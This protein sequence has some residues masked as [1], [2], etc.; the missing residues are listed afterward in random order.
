MTRFGENLPIWQYYKNHGQI[1]K[2]L[3]SV[4]QNFEPTLAHCIKETLVLLFL[5]R[6]AHW[7]E[8]ERVEAN[9]FGQMNY[10]LPVNSFPTKSQTYFFHCS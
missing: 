4:W 1:Y 8:L 9:S 6:D 5:V 10:A 7:I 3:F 2:G